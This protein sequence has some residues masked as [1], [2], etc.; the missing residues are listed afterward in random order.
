MLQPSPPLPVRPP[1]DQRMPAWRRRWAGQRHFGSDAVFI[2]VLVLVCGLSA[3]IG[4][5]VPLHSE[6]HDMFFLLDNAYRVVQGQVPHR[7]FSS[8]WGPVIYLVYAGGLVLSGMQPTAIVYAN[9]VFGSVIAIWA[10]LITRTRWNSTSACVVGIYT[11][12]LITAPSPLGYDPRDFGYAMVYNRYSYAIFG[13]ILMECASAMMGRTGNASPT[14][15][16]V[17]QCANGAISTGFALGLLTFLKISYG[18]VAALF[19]A[20]SLIGIDTGRSRR[21]VGICAGFVTLALLVLCYLR[22]DLSNMLQD[23]TIAAAARRVSL[24]ILHPIGLLDAIQAVTIFVF[25]VWKLGSEPQTIGGPAPRLG[26][27]L[28]ALMTVVTGY[29]LLISNQQSG[30]FPLNGFAAV[31]LVADYGRSGEKSLGWSDFRSESMKILLLGD[32]LPAALHA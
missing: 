3:F 29:L 30:T 8:A 14:D 6:G 15:P 26:R 32:L 10:Y 21:L 18:M 16:W 17:R 20:S 2:S 27:A 19:V 5:A 9:A 22:F 7:D 12:L 1:E 4:L 11:I 23:L 25:V 24:R 13:I 28:F 31:A